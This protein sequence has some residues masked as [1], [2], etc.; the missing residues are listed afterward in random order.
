[1]AGLTA[2]AVEVSGLTGARTDPALARAIVAL[3]AA[4][5]ALDERL[6]RRRVS[7][8]LDEAD[9]E[10]DLVGRRVEFPGYRPAEYLRGR[11]A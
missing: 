5:E 4:R 9:R 8:L 10:L 3:R 11:L 2:L 7:D 1:L 6:P